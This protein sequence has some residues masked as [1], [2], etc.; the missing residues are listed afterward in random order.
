MHTAKTTHETLDFL[1]NNYLALCEQVDVDS[2]SPERLNVCFKEKYPARP[3]RI[4][5]WL[6][7]LGY[8]ISAW[9]LWEY[10]SRSL[11]ESLPHK[12][13]KLSKESTVDWVARSLAANLRQ[14]TDHKWFV[15]ANCVRNLIAHSGGRVDGAKGHTS[16]QRS[17]TAFPNIETW[18]DG[19]LALEHEHVAELQIKIEDYIEETA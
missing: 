16:L 14:F 15:S 12:K 17:Q 19:Y 6:A 3:F 2:M 10:Y 5:A 7:R 1:W 4:S 9:S 11:C 8:F 13:R 18:Q